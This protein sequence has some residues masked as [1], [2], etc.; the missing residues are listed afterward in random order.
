MFKERSSLASRKLSFDE[1]SVLAKTDQAGFEA[2][3]SALIDCVINIPGGNTAQL[4]ALQRRLDGRENT[5]KAAYLSCLVLSEWL[6][7]TYQ[8]LSQQIAAARQQG[9]AD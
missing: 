6:G 4:S 9:Y 2:L 1:L 3:R 5:G 8:E 7:D